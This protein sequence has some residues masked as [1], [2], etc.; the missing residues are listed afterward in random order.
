[1]NN[2][3]RLIKLY[4]GGRV[5]HALTEKFINSGYDFWVLKEGVQYEI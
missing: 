1:M 3:E 5:N 4:L 2:R